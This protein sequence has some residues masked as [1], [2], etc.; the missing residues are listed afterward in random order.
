VFH[1]NEQLHL[2]QT[3]SNQKHYIYLPHNNV[4]SRKHNKLAC[5]NLRISLQSSR[6]A[7]LIVNPIIIKEAYLP[8]LNKFLVPG[9]QYINTTNRTAVSISSQS[10]RMAVSLLFQNFSILHHN[11]KWLGSQ[12]N[13]AWN[14]LLL[15]VL[16]LRMHGTI[17]SIPQTYVRYF[18]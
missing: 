11:H 14:L 4:L 17:P 5:I 1:C 6:L 2:N 7:S 13:G 9:K 16:Q 12:A 8:S 3:Y 10:W 18:G 15:L